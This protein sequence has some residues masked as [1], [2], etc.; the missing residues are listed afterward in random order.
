MTTPLG[1]PDGVHV[2]AGLV[3]R[4]VDK[5]LTLILG[6]TELAIQDVDVRN[7]LLADLGVVRG[8]SERAR[9]L[10]DRLHTLSHGRTAHPVDLDLAA[11]L[12]TAAPALNLV[13]GPR[14]SVRVHAQ[15][16][17]VVRIDPDQLELILMQLVLNGAEA[18]DGP[19][20]VTISVRGPRAVTT[21]HVAIAVRDQ[22]RGMA[23][24]IL[25]QCTEPFFTTKPADGAV[26][27]GL[28]VVCMA[29][30]HAGG[31]LRMASRPSRGTTAT[32]LLPRGAG[33]KTTPAPRGDLSPTDAGAAPLRARSGSPSHAP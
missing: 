14:I 6:Y 1:T 15:P 32:I 16:G 5:L 27:L 26:G 23:S 25:R 4:E 7:E 19:G 2:L 21:G 20:V 22:G 30:T 33:T 10:T 17:A 29:A 31:E 18:Y 3:A 9:Q 12:Q 24:R 11:W 8:S 28:P 13:V